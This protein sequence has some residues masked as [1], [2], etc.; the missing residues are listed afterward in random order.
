MSLIMTKMLELWS[1]R[2][3]H[4]DRFDYQQWVVSE[5]S[6]FGREL[7]HLEEDR[8]NILSTFLFLI[9]GGNRRKLCWVL[10]SKEFSLVITLNLYNTASFLKKI[11]CFSVESFWICCRELECQDMVG[12][13]FLNEALKMFEL[14]WWNEYRSL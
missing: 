9:S 13:K 11:F 2:R 3:I 10:S 6:D 14:Q 4:D 1:Q 7:A 8:N 5:M 12:S